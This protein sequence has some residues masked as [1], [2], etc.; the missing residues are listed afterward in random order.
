MRDLHPDL[1]LPA[2]PN[3][4]PSEIAKPVEAQIPLGQTPQGRHAAR[5]E[6]TCDE[7]AFQC[8]LRPT[9]RS[10]H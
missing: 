9:F 6:S 10:A 3:A 5:R 2:L 4:S 1:L 7:G 8:A